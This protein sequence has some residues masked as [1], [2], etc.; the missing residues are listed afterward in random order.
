MPRLLLLIR[1]AHVVETHLA[2][3]GLFEDLFQGRRCLIRAVAGGRAA[4]DLR[5]PVLVIA[6]REL[7][8]GAS[9]ESCKRGER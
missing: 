2:G 3:H 5:R 4:V 1:H 6:H 8:A 9:L 7:R